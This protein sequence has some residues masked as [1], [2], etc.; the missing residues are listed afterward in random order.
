MSCHAMS[1]FLFNGKWRSSFSTVRS[2][3]RFKLAAWRASREVPVSLMDLST[4]WKC[5]FSAWS[6]FSSSRHPPQASSKYQF[7]SFVQSMELHAATHRP[8]V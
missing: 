6:S 1:I 5:H 8:K 3:K 7:L 4:K 2:N